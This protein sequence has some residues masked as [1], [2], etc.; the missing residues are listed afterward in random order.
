MLTRQDCLLQ[1]VEVQGEQSTPTS[2]SHP[3]TPSTQL[4]VNP[5]SWSH[6]HLSPL[7]GQSFC[8]KGHSNHL[9]QGLQQLHIYLST[10]CLQLY[11]FLRFLPI[12]LQSEPNMPKPQMY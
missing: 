12:S 2:A 7:L 5:T 10:Q 3:S 9:H 4:Q 6:Q 11:F 1:R 8:L